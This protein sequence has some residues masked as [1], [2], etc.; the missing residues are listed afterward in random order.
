MREFP[1]VITK[2]LTQGLRPKKE[3]S[4]PNEFLKECYNMK[5]SVAGLQRYDGATD[6]FSTG[7]NTSWPW[8]QLFLT[9]DYRLLAQETEVS[10]VGSGTLP[11]G[12]TSLDLKDPKNPATSVNVPTSGGPWQFVSFGESWF[13]SK[14]N[15]TVFKLGYDR[16]TGD[17]PEYFL[18][19]S[20]TINAISSHRG[21]ILIGGFDEANFWSTAWTD[22]FT[23]WQ[24]NV[25]DGNTSYQF[26]D[27][28]ENWIAWSSIGEA[29]F[30]AWLFFPDNVSSSLGV[31]EHN[32]LQRVRRNELGWM[33][34]PFQ[35]KVLSIEPL[36][37][38][39]VVYGTDGIAILSLTGVSNVDGIGDPTASTYGVVFSYNV[40]LHS[41]NA[42]AVSQERH[43]FLS[44]D[45]QL[46]TL[47]A[48]FAL[49]R[50]D[51]QEY[52]GNMLSE[53]V[54]AFYEPYTEEYHFCSSAEGFAF[55]PQGLYEHKDRFTTLNTE[56]GTTY[57]L[58]HSPATTD[59]QVQTVPIDVR[60][61]SKK[62][63]NNVQVS[64]PGV[65]ELK[66]NIHTRY[67]YT[68][69]WQ[70]TGFSTNNKEGVNHRRVNGLEFMVELQGSA[71]TGAAVNQITLRYQLPDKRAIRGPF[72][73][74]S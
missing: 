58:S 43:V 19:T 36:G 46:F 35:G 16:I 48:E 50:L 15:A 44:S 27:V 9:Q 20:T 60:I 41:R 47:N 52:L 45:G 38:G 71:T 3:I 42:V 11:W 33:Q 5:P 1:L 34:M 21:R 69:P 74:V 57:G 28:G 65:E 68:E 49:E 55:A 37:N 17:S 14:E 4:L 62:R 64:A 8:P 23:T 66:T 26:D 40:G 30:P 22:V 61:Q 7:V 59:I 10:M 73:D 31:T 63:I 39:V 13:L 12:L 70:D 56:H 2:A 54:N 72:P 18:D 24:N 67:S 53:E 51:Y 29:D 25:A 32:I 6:P